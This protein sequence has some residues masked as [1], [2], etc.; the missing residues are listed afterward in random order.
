MSG[1]ARKSETGAQ[2]PN[3]EAEESE[4]GKEP[5]QIPERMSIDPLRVVLP[6]H[7]FAGFLGRCHGAQRLQAGTDKAPVKV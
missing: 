5:Q 1:R 4:S 3:A 6:P 7:R 2:N